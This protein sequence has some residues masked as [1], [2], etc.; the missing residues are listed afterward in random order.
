MVAA[1][2][3]DAAMMTAH[4]AADMKMDKY[5]G[6]LQALLMSNMPVDPVASPKNV[7]ETLAPEVNS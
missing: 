6:L 2:A 1:T 7:T 3:T 5:R 4:V